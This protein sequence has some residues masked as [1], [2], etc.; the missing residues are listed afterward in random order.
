M[1]ETNFFKLMV[2]GVAAKDAK[3]LKDTKDF[4]DGEGAQEIP[5]IEEA[6]PPQ[7]VA[8]MPAPS[9]EASRSAPPA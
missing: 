3:D 6:V 1:R 8:E 2:A 7:A 5:E 4:K 9:C